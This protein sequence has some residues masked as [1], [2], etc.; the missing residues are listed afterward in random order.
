[1][2][3]KEDDNVCIVCWREIGVYAVGLCDHP[4]CHECSTRMRVLCR[5]SE[6]P[7]CRRNLPKVIFVKEVKPFEELN[8]RL[9][10]V[11]ARP[12][13]YFESE[14]VRKAYKELLENRCKYCPAGDEARV[15]VNFAQLCAHVRKEHR[16]AFCSLCVEHL[17]IFP[18]ERTAYTKKDLLRHQH[19]GDPEDTSH[20]GHP[21]CQFCNVRYFDNDEL[22]RHLRR[23]HYYCHFCG[24]D[25]RLQYY[26]SYEFLRAHFR[27]EHFLCEEGDCKN[28]T[29]TAAFRTEIDLKAHKAQQHGKA[30]GKARAKQERTLELEFTIRPRNAAT[31]HGDRRPPSSGGVVGGD[32]PEEAR[33]HDGREPRHARRGR[34]NRDSGR[35]ERAALNLLRLS[36]RRRPTTTES[37]ETQRPVD[38]RCEKE[39]PQLGA[40]GASTEAAGNRRATALV[41]ASTYP[42][43]KTDR[44]DVNS[45]DEFPSLQAPA[46][47]PQRNGT[48]LFRYESRRGDGCGPAVSVRV[49]RAT[50][51][52]DVGSA[53]DA[54]PS[55][56]PER[57]TLERPAGLPSERAFDDAFPALTS[58][59]SATIPAASA[60]SSPA[61]ATR[62]SSQPVQTVP[63][64]R[65]PPPSDPPL[66]RVKIKTKKKKES[67][68]PN[69]DLPAS[70]APS[71]EDGRERSRAPS[72]S[73]TT[74]HN[75]LRL[76]SAARKENRGTEE[77]DGA[78]S[79]SDGSEDSSETRAAPVRSRV[80][81]GPPGTTFVASDFP[82][83]DGA[84]PGFGAPRAC[85]KPPPGFAPARRPPSAPVPAGVENGS[86]FRPPSPPE[87]AQP[88]GF[89]Q[90]NLK[91]IRDVQKMLGKR[92]E[93]AF[94]KFKALS[95][96]FRQGTVAAEEYFAEC[97]ELFGGEEEFLAVFSELL[98]LLPD[99][100]KQQELM[101]TYNARRRISASAA[102]A[103]P[104]GGASPLRF[105]VCATCQQVLSGDDFRTHTAVHEPA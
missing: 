65:P 3:V 9:Y 41:P 16:R 68:R 10:P 53:A 12:Q 64:A 7:I 72:P 48:V 85:P 66:Q 44:I 2:D 33:G 36:D 20:R 87:Y 25:Y 30:L 67:V 40:D 31:H 90:R 24:D 4:V 105:L 80:L 18:R 91:L 50:G 101:R 88:A 63:S 104:K 99:I 95:G 77:T 103:F 11:D 15:F 58:R 57:L 54:R 14:E 97:V 82:A 29:F 32:D 69:G 102:G 84:P 86:K 43:R 38:Y 52:R 59:P 92:D 60:S 75:L 42:A 22:Y 56:A 100:A 81:R 61:T 98:F 89:A 51:D 70:V 27:Q 55:T 13:I 71:P 5:K 46:D 17:R 73:E 93:G 8:E 37:W 74:T 76:I 19:S 45:V 28:E 49:S 47:A 62:A 39:F 78:A 94:A 96:G 23:E 26:R 34:G 21:M 35:D 6:C 79:N 83:L 1:M